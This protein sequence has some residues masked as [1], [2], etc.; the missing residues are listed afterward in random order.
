MTTSLDFTILVLAFFEN[1]LRMGINSTFLGWYSIQIAMMIS[2][3]TNWLSF[4]TS[5]NELLVGGMF[6]FIRSRGSQRPTQKPP[7]KRTTNKRL[8]SNLVSSQM[9]S[10]GSCSFQRMILVLKKFELH[11][12]DIKRLK[13]LQHI[14]KWTW[15]KTVAFW[16]CKIKIRFY[17]Y[18]A[19]WPRRWHA[20]AVKIVLKQNQSSR[21]IPSNHWTKLSALFTRTPSEQRS[22]VTILCDNRMHYKI[23]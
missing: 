12:M 15:I 3:L 16:F 18:Y 6:G 2:E 17:N 4:Q 13:H 21:S 22:I 8:V 20:F 19:Q 7:H 10:F 14:Q 11:S 23:L 5:S 9:L 1:C